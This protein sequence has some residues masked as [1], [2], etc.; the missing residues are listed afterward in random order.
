MSYSLVIRM[1]WSSWRRAWWNIPST[2]WWLPVFRSY[3]SPRNISLST[4]QWATLHRSQHFTL[5]Q[6]YCIVYYNT[7]LPLY[8]SVM[9]LTRLLTLV[10]TAEGDLFFSQR[11][12]FR[13][14]AQAKQWPRMLWILGF[15]NRYIEIQKQSL[16]NL[17]NKEQWKCC[18]KKT[19]PF[20]LRASIVSS[21]RSKCG[22]PFIW[23]RTSPTIQC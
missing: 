22:L 4:S 5:H 16:N 11:I 8:L 2:N 15:Q 7:H 12:I 1:A 13:S 20:A 6:G 9:Y 17:D 23:K 3:Q 10:R 18:L 19:Y 14:F 21:T